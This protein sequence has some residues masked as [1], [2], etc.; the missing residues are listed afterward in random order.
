MA[1]PDHGVPAGTSAAPLRERR[2]AKARLDI[3]RVALKLFQENADVRAK[4][5]NLLQYVCIDETQ[6][7]SS[8]QWEISRLLCATHKNL[9]IADKDGK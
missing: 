3:A 4:Y 1:G 2:K 8:V 9:F 6:D 5:Q 7:T